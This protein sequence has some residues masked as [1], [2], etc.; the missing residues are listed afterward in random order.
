MGLSAQ[1]AAPYPDGG[2][3]RLRIALFE[4]DSLDFMLHSGL[5]IHTPEDRV[6]YDPGGYWADPRAVRRYDVTRGLSPELEESYLS[7]QS[8]VS[9]PDFWK[10]HLWETEVPDAVAR[11]AVEIAEARTPYVFG[12]CSYGVTSLLRQLPGFEDIRVTF[13]PAELAAQLR[14]RNDLRY[15]VRDLGAEAQE[16]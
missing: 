5:I 9:G 2:A 10:L 8:L 7:R 16:A 4:V 12:G 13:V 6:L 11:Q 1:P 14:A 3:S 15:S